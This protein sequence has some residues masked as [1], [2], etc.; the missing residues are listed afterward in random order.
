VRNG[1][2]TINV[3]RLARHRREPKGRQR[4]LSREEYKTLH[5]GIAES[6]PEHLAEFV[7][8]VHT[9]MRLS[10]Q[11]SLKW[12][13]VDFAR[14]RIELT[15]TKN[16]EPRTV[17]LNQVA[18]DALESIRPVKPKP[19]DLVFT[20]ATKNFQ[21]RAWFDP[22]VASVGIDDYTWHNNRHTFGSWLAM[23][24]ASAKEIQEAGGWKTIQMA[25]RYSHL[26]PSHTCSVVDRITGP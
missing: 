20:S 13:Q 22:C 12:R 24:G 7:V 10:E 23:A 5:N 14:K 1:K 3:A 21:Q 8:S 9:G 16:T 2:V 26:S 18:L 19:A 17:H 4:F 6:Y 11:Y 15:E 25:A